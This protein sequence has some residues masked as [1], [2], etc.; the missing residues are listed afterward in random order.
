MNW[1]KIFRNLRSK[2]DFEEM[3]KKIANFDCL[4]IKFPCLVNL[5]MY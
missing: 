4:K 5:Y 1:N 2:F 3:K